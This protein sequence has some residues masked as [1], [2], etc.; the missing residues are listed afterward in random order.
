MVAEVL[1]VTLKVRKAA[2]AA[3][4]IASKE[5]RSKGG[6]MDGAFKHDLSKGVDER[7]ARC[8]KLLLWLPSG[9]AI[10]TEL[11]LRSSCFR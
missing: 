8:V 6:V 10:A 2:E 4:K 1:R 5:L 3:R 11:R 7:E 9:P